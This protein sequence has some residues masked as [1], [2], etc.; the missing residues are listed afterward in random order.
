MGT[1][2]AG[3]FPQSPQGVREMK[4]VKRTNVDEIRI[5]PRHARRVSILVHQL[6]AAG[7]L[8]HSADGALVSAANRIFQ[9]ETRSD[10]GEHQMIAEIELV[11]AMRDRANL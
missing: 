11:P 9:R 6:I 8:A 3:L 2:E 10:H 7:P 4:F 5:F 1:P